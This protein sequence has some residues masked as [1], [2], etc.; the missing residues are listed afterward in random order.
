M[1][2]LRSYDQIKGRIA[3]EFNIFEKGHTYYDFVSGA[4]GKQL[5]AAMKEIGFK[6]GKDR[7]L[8]H[9]ETPLLI[10]FLNAPVAIG[11]EII[12]K[13]NKIKTARGVL[14]ILSPTDIVKDRLVWWAQYKDRQALEQAALVAIDNKIDLAA[15]KNGRKLKRRQG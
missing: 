13:T 4:D 8:S 14:K 2:D 5:A 11:E 1:G 15:I 12:E 3:S 7:Y 10:E 6:V 9:P